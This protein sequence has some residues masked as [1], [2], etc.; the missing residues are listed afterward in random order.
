MSQTEKR[1]SG[2]IPAGEEPFNAPDYEPYGA[3]DSYNFNY[4]KNMK[5]KGK[6]GRPVHTL[7]DRT[8]LAVPS[9]RVTIEKFSAKLHLKNGYT[10]F[11]GSIE[12]EHGVRIECSSKGVRT[13]IVF[14]GP[15]EDRRRA[16]AYVCNQVA[17]NYQVLI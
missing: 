2:G 11:M 1:F 6:G 16:S 14:S 7:S 9:N 8:E 3:D 12:K 10:K 15:E 5:K 13:L 4:A 17:P